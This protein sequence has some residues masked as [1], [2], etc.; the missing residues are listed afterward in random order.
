[1]RK[2]VACLSWALVFH[3]ILLVVPALSALD[4]VSGR[5]EGV[6]PVVTE[7]FAAGDPTRVAVSLANVWYRDVPD[8][9]KLQ[10]CL[11]TALE[12]APGV[13]VNPCEYEPPAFGAPPSFPG[14]F[15][16]EAMY[17]NA[18]TF[19]TYISSNGA[20]S[21]ALLVL[22]LEATGANEGALND[23]N[24][25]VFNRIR[26]RIDVP[27]AGTYRVTHPYGSRDYLVATP[28]VRAINQ[29]QDFG[30]DIAQNF[31]VAMRDGQ[32]PPAFP[33]PS[34][35]SINL[36]I[37]N[38]DGAGVGPFLLP[39]NPHGGVFSAN[40]PATFVGGP[41]TVGGVTYIALP[42][43]PNPTNPAV[44]IDVFQP[45]TGSVFIPEDETESANYFRI[46]L[47]DPVGNF[48]LNPA[49]LD[50]PQRV[51]F[52]N[53]LLVGKV[54]DDRANIVPTAV[55][56]AAGT[57]TGSNANIDVV[58]NDFD[59]LTAG[60][61][62]GIHPQ[63]IAVADSNGPIRNAAGM[64][65][66]TASHPTAAGG[67][68]RRVTSIPTGKTTFLY[69][70]PN[71]FFAGTDSFQYVVQDRGGL[72][73]LAASVDI[74]VE[75]LRIDRADYRP[76]LGKWHLRGTSSDSLNNSVT[77]YGGARSRLTPEEEVQT[78]AVS[79]DARG[80]V[81]LRVAAN[82]IEFLLSVDPLPITA[83]TAAHIH[84][85]A[86][87]TNGPIIF[88]LF[89]SGFGIP[90]ASPHSSVLTP[91]NLQPRPDAG[92]AT[93]SDALAAIRSGNAY[94]NVHTTAFPAG[95]IRGQLV[96]P[97]IGSA[98]VVD[99]IW[100]FSGHSTA[101]PGALSNVSGESSNGVQFF[102]LPLR[103]R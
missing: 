18:S 102:G 72:I 81:A 32:V 28:G 83:V 11:D 86:A 69:T 38:Q 90:F 73:S 94:V 71:A 92:I 89:D 2:Y 37:I 48:Q 46:E 5:Q 58:A 36:G 75:D 97:I 87:G 88:S 67:T 6:P 45:V 47:L 44:P 43:A 25:A 85:G 59:V 66:L 95:E 98:V 49:N 70:P 17:W 80:N 15:G 54:F 64:P 77:L 19:G 10:L 20:S 3:G 62:Y 9:L 65:M 55:G 13:V 93:F 29:T 39:A 27:V 1:M 14:N 42:F 61:A 96:Q 23:G 52:D 56:D 35:P 91:A 79:S 30:L 74:T 101:S 60:N 57:A 68:V 53:F 99:G 21:S 103:L 100:E 22:A 12:V 4:A 16:A 82:S 33:A 24:Q 40:D 63:A 78:P 31:L 26:I 76:R 84:V 8:G 50:N 51:Q 7:I 41:I 34:P